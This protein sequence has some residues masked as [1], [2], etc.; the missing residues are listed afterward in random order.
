MPQASGRGRRKF[1]A[2]PRG[3]R[4]KALSVPPRLQENNTGKQRCQALSGLARMRGSRRDRPTYGMPQGM[5]RA[6]AVTDA[7]RSYQAARAPPRA[8]HPGPTDRALLFTLPARMPS[9]S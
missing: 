2:V 9:R 6:R 1:P 5:M 4:S 8:S 7:T 3:T